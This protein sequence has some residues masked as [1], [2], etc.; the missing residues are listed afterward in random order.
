MQSVVQRRGRLPGDTRASDDNNIESPEH[1]LG[2]AERFPDMTLDA[3]ACNRRTGRLAGY[4]Q[5]EPGTIELIGNSQ[6]GDP[7]IACLAAA[8]PEYPLVVAWLGESRLPGK[9]RQAGTQ[10]KIRRTAVPGPWRD[11][12]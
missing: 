10:G 7:A 4:G 11:V 6:H 1:V 3:V 2:V 5:P 8:M 9:T 12:P